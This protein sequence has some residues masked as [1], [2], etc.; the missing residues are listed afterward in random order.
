MIVHRSVQKLFD[1]AKDQAVTV[2]NQEIQ[3]KENEAIYME[4]SQKYSLDEINV[5][6]AKNGFEPL[7]K[8]QIQKMVYRCYLES[9]II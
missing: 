5:M 1:H 2:N 9:C 8:S 6:A 3:F 7:K 4:I